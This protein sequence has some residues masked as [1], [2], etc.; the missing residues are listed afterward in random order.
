[1]TTDLDAKYAGCENSGMGLRVLVQGFG[2]FSSTA[3]G[4]AASE[5]MGTLAPDGTLR[6]NDND[7]FPV[8]K[9]VRMLEK[10]AAEVGEQVI[11]QV[12]ERI[13]ANAVFP[14][15][16][17]SIE[18]AL[19]SLDVAMHM[20]HRKNGKPMF[21]PASGQWQEGIGHLAYQKVEGKNE[22]HIRA[23]SPYRCAMD[24]GLVVT[25]ARRFQPKSKVVHAPEPR[26]KDKGGTQC[27]YVVTW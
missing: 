1:M 26:C 19:A 7:W 6:V 5:G 25:M 3:A 23:D 11:Y 20:N 15:Q 2:V 18:T 24:H 27:L 9:F 22:I 4:Y 8:A 13:P 16:I 21:D 17:N 12:G 14:P 10:I